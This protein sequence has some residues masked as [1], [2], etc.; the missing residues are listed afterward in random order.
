MAL[1]ELPW[2]TKLPGYSRQLADH[3]ARRGVELTSISV[4]A[5]TTPGQPAAEGVDPST[6]TQAVPITIVSTGKGLE[7]RYFL[8]DVQQVGPRRALVIATSMVPNEEGSIE[9]PSTM[10]VQL[11]VFSSPVDDATREQLKE[12]LGRRVLG[13]GPH[14]GQSA[15]VRPSSPAGTTGVRRARASSAGCAARARPV[16]GRLH[17]PRGADGDQPDHR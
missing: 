12:I 4:G 2:E 15:L 10:T 5:S 14:E 7:L 16:R 11:T 3:A 13:L 8:R 6:T 17:A 9:G 1:A